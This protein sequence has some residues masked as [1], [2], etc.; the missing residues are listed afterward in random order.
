MARRNALMQLAW[1]FRPKSV[2]GWIVLA[3][4]AGVYLLAQ[5]ALNSAFGLNLP[6]LFG[7]SSDESRPALVADDTRPH[8]SEDL[9]AQVG[10]ER[11]GTATQAGAQTGTATETQTDRGGSISK[12]SQAGDGSAT[13]ET[14]VIRSAGETKAPPPL[15]RLKDIGG[16][17]YETTA[18][19]RYGPGSVD[20][21]RLK[22][23][24]KHA[25]DSPGRPVHGVFDPGEERKVFAAVDEAYLIADLRGPP[26]AKKK[27][28]GNR[29]IWMVDMKRTVGYLGGQVGQ[30]KNNPPLTGI[31]LVL[32]GRNVITAYP[33]DPSR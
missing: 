33:D 6:G 30:R 20:G 14:P 25:K 11:G 4:A 21:H 15:G 31:R 18:G 27:T 29:T 1:R 2:A 23:V 8:D 32:E 3:T 24:M 22:H 17:V 12:S 10:G 19:L 28:E 9:L 26:Q 16:G 13:A 7:G 5:P